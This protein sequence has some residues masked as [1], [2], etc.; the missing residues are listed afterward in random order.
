MCGNENVNS[1]VAMKTAPLREGMQGIVRES[2]Q[3]G[4]VSNKQPEK[5]SLNVKCRVHPFTEHL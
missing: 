5:L 1:S 4:L 2:V 3:L